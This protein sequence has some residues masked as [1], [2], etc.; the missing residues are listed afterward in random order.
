MLR[1]CGIFASDHRRLRCAVAQACPICG[2]GGAS[3]HGRVGLGYFGGSEVLL[4]RRPAWPEKGLLG[5]LGRAPGN[6]VLIGL[7][8]ATGPQFPLDNTP[9]FR[10]HGYL[11]LAAVGPIE[12]GDFAER[13]LFHVPAHLARNLPPGANAE[14]LF[15]LFLSYVHDMGRLDDPGLAPSVLSE[16][17]RSTLLLLPKLLDGPAPAAALCVTNGA[18]MVATASGTDLWM[19][20]S[21]GIRACPA[22]SEPARSAKHDPELVDHPAVKVVSI[23]HLDGPDGLDGFAR[24]PDRQVVTATASGEVLSR[25]I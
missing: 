1:F 6:H 7:D 21:D 5:M 12:R 17:A 4:M 9:P 18:H 16:A 25:S 22:C 24:L 8:D 23:A 13:V 19:R 20:V 15:R 10:F 2:V 11:G 14:L 3:F